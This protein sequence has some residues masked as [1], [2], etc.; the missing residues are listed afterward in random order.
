METKDREATPGDGLEMP[1]VKVSV[2]EQAL[3]GSDLAKIVRKVGEAALALA[4]ARQIANVFLNE[5]QRMDAM[6]PTEERVPIVTDRSMAFDDDI[7]A[8]NGG[9]AWVEI[10]DGKDDKG[11]QVCAPMVVSEFAAFIGEFVRHAVGPG[12][13][14]GASAPL[15]RAGGRAAV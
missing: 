1:H 14:R 11:A 7:R 15:D 10:Q 13:P 8:S 6:W 5:T 3:Y 2:A 9:P 12:G 4:D